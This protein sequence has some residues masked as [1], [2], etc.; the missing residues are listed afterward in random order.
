MPSIYKLI[1]QFRLEQRNTEILDIQLETGDKYEKSN[2]SK[3]REERIR[4]V[5]DSYDKKIF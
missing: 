2:K 1:E 5:L 4:S 3:R